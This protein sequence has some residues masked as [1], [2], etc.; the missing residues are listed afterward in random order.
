MMMVHVVWPFFV[1]NMV[2]VLNNDLIE[3]K[4]S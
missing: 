4:V 2:L 1:G 3:K